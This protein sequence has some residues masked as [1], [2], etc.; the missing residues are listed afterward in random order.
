MPAFYRAC[1]LACIP[2]RAEPFGRTA[3][4]AFAVGTPVVASTVG[5]LQEILT[6]GETGVLVP[7]GD[8]TALADSLRRLLASPDLRQKICTNARR[9]AEEKYHEHKYEERV[10]LLVS[11]EV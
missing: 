6:D 11:K 5:G 10:K 8:E 2:S 1:D 7:Y 3:I 4:E 9:E